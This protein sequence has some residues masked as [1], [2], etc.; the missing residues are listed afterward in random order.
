M[1]SVAALHGPETITG[2]LLD[3]PEHFAIAH[4][5]NCLTVRPHGLSAS[6]AKRHPDADTYAWRRGVGPRNLAVSADRS[7]PGTNDVIKT[8]SGR[9]VVAMYAQWAPGKPMKYLSYPQTYHD[10]SE[11]R[12]KWFAQCLDAIDANPSLSHVA[13]PKFV[14][15]GLA[16]G[17]WNVYEKMIRDVHA[18]GNTTFALFDLAQK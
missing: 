5:C 1:A 15:C 9:T 18:R 8:A 12:A 13:L 10:S 7:E 2:D 11:N 3:A 17:D 4:Q 16:G 6:I 14:G